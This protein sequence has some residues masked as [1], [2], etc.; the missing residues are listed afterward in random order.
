MK[1]SLPRKSKS[2]R[3]VVEVWRVEE[4][5]EMKEGNSSDEHQGK[6]TPR[7]KRTVY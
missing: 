6:G 5:E 4:K 3:M 7:K 2:R 1:D